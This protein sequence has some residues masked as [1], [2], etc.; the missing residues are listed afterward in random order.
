MTT[1]AADVVASFYQAAA[2]YGFPASLLTDNGAIFTAAPRGGG[3][4]AIELE[5]DALGIAA[6][7]ARPYHPQTCGKVE[8]FHQTLKRWLVRQPCPI[9]IADL[10][11][12][13]D[14]FASYYNHQRPHRALGRRPPRPPSPPA[15]RR[16]RHGQGSRH[17]ATTASA[18]TRSTAPGSSPCATT[19]GCT[20]SGWAA[21][22]PGSG[23]W[24]WSPIWTCG[25][26]PNT[27]NSCA[28]SP[29]IPAAT[30]SRST[31]HEHGTMSR[32]RYARCPETS[33]CG[34]DR[35]R[36]CV[37]NAGDFTGRTANTSRVPFHPYLDPIIAS[38]VHQ[39]PAGGF[40]RPSASLPVSPRP[41][42]PG[43]GRREVGG[44]S[45][46]PVDRRST[47]TS[48]PRWLASQPSDGCGR[49]IRKA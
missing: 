37:G 46:P 17:P 40:R 23:C 13:L 27:G 4:C 18:T 9:T 14:W 6:R 45:R 2:A 16:H 47:P 32:H 10:Q 12:Q 8:R 28:S 36:T 29:W 5:L 7:H 41:A 20:T 22:T 24:S 31:S 49:G 39:R 19:A 21:A 1:K 3:R 43:V 38:D 11:A 48:F 33:Q 30:T 42:R 34:R 35:I 44:K 25:S 26:S 15:P